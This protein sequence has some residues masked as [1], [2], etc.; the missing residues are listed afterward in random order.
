MEQ[1]ESLRAP[2]RVPVAQL[3]PY[4]KTVA[5]EFP[6]FRQA[7]SEVFGMVDPEVALRAPSAIAHGTDDGVATVLRVKHGF[8]LRHET[9]M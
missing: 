3:L 9:N 5:I 1:L 8:H 7:P 2:K 6:L 4:P